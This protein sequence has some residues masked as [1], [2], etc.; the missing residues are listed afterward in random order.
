MLPFIFDDLNLSWPYEAPSVA[1]YGILPCLLCLMPCVGVSSSFRFSLFRLARVFAASHLSFPLRGLMAKDDLENTGF[2]DK[3]L[4]PPEHDPALTLE[5]RRAI[6]EERQRR[7]F[8]AGMSRFEKE[9]E[10]RRLLME[11]QQQ[12]AASSKPQR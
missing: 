4:P 2:S 10:Q 11:Q 5:G 9:E 1:S 3:P 8:I 6:F 12:A 7:G